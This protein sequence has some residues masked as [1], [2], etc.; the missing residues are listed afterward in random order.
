[1]CHAGCARTHRRIE[2][3]Q[4]SS[5]RVSE[6]LETPNLP[7]T[8]GARPALLA[9]PPLPPICLV[10]LKEGNSKSKSQEALACTPGFRLEPR[11]RRFGQ[12]LVTSSHAIPF[13]YSQFTPFSGTFSLLILFPGGRG[14]VTSACGFIKNTVG[15]GI[16]SPVSGESKCY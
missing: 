1:M 7:H 4:I 16:V 15:S 8:H 5:I 13:Q 9:H 14:A 6:G 11:T 10:L 12:G 3:E 2:L